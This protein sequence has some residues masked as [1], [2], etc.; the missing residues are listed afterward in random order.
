MKSLRAKMSQCPENERRAAVRWQ[1]ELL[2]SA[3]PAH[4][5]STVFVRNLS[6]RGLMI[7]TDADLQVGDWIE[8]DLQGADTTDARVVWKQEYSYGCE[9]AEPIPTA[10]VSAALLQ[11]PLD[12]RSDR[13]ESRIEEIPVAVSPSVSELAEWKAAFERTRGEEG[14]SII[15]YRQTSSGLLIAIAGKTE[16]PV[17]A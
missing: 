1:V 4:E 15:A 11:A 7:Q 8:V 10:V 9:F 12:E 14:Y 13:P 16:Q 6:E 3:G 2:V 17:E 5:R